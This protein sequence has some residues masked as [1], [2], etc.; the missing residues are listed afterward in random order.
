MGVSLQPHN[1][2]VISTCSLTYATLEKYHERIPGEKFHFH[3]AV[4][5]ATSS[6]YETADHVEMETKLPVGIIR[7]SIANMQSWEGFQRLQGHRGDQ[8]NL[9]RAGLLPTNDPLD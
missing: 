2:V 7:R 8:P 3:A 9:L 4:S 5:P 1:A 6:E